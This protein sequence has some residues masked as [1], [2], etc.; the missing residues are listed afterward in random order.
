MNWYKI[1]EDEREHF[2]SEA[3]ELLEDGHH[4]DYELEDLARE[5]YENQ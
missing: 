4:K 2:R 5:L 3:R 1:F